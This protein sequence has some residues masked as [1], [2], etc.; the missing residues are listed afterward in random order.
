MPDLSSL[1][2]YERDNQ[3]VAEVS[4]SGDPGIVYN[5]L[6]DNLVQQSANMRGLANAMSQEIVNLSEFVDVSVAEQ[7]VAAEQ[8]FGLTD[9][10]YLTDIEVFMTSGVGVTLSEELTAAGF[11]LLE[12][13]A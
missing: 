6:G 12:A 9:A 8:L 3:W 10:V 5:F 1:L 7:G 4:N 13:L 11:D 2:L